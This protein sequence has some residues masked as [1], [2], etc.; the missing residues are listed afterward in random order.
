MFI[1]DTCDML[2]VVMP[3]STAAVYAVNKLAT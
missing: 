3:V 1:D 2:W